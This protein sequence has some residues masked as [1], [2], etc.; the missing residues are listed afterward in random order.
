MSWL[1]ILKIATSLVANSDSILVIEETGNFLLKYKDKIYKILE[2][3]EQKLTRA[4]L[5]DL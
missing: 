4:Y 1:W 3:S 2:G 5:E